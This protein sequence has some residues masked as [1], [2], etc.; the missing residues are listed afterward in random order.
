[1]A[2]IES[3]EVLQ[4]LIAKLRLDAARENIPNETG[5]ILM[6]VFVVNPEPRILVLETNLNDG[7]SATMSTTHVTKRTFITSC[8][9]SV[10]KSALNPSIASDIR[11][12]PFNG[13][14]SLIELRYE[15]SVAGSNVSGF[16]TF[17]PPIE[18]RPNTA[19]TI[20]N[21]SGT[22]SIDTSAIV[23]FFE[24]EQ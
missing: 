5:N 1:M 19:I 21:T 17:N 11:A 20:N 9:I 23:T 14:R 18:I 24:L 10:A 16:I 12:F 8:R 13:T 6:P 3:S 15:P 7:T 22:A 4:N 2:K